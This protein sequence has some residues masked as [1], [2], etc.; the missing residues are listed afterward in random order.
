V[1]W[2]GV[3]LS[4]KEGYLSCASFCMSSDA[5]A[6]PKGIR[7]ALEMSPRPSTTG[8]TVLALCP[9]LMDRPSRCPWRENANSE[10]MPYVTAGALYSSN[11]NSDVT[12]VSEPSLRPTGSCEEGVGQPLRHD[13]RL[14]DPLQ[15]EGEEA[16][17]QRGLQQVRVHEQVPVKHA[18]AVRARVGVDLD[19]VPEQHHVPPVL[20]LAVARD[21]VR[22]VDVRRVRAAEA[23]APGVRARVDADGAL[24]AQGGVVER[25]LPLEDGV[26][27]AHDDDI[28]RLRGE[29]AARGAVPSRG[30]GGWVVGGGE[31]GREW[32]TSGERRTGDVVEEENAFDDVNSTNQ[33][34]RA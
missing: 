22:A 4:G 10:S 6:P 19:V 8:M 23:R 5:C 30:H 13:D 33:H 16:K 9:R 29:R 18:L 12:G 31:G 24:A 26:R 28:V 15:P 25:L 7:L 2:D 17:V 27:V 20:A 32:G 3:T 34:R 14:L 1:N 21:D 11:S